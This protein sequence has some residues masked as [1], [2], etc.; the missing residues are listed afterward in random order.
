MERHQKPTQKTTAIL[1][2]GLLTSLVLLGTSSEPPLVSISDVPNLESGTRVELIGLLVELRIYDSGAEGLVLAD[3]DGGF[4]ARV[5]CSGG[6]RP[7]PSSYTSIGDE[8]RVIGDISS[9]ETGTLVFTDSDKIAISRESEA[10]LSVRTV[11]S[12]WMLFE[13]DTIRINGIVEMDGSGSGLRLVECSGGCSIAVGTNQVSLDILVGQQVI[14]TATLDF[15]RRTS[16][17]VL[18]VLYAVPEP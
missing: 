11:S 8:L 17:L 1:L 7:Q 4:T 14:V 13:G 10:V 16:S 15:D 3:A 6:I 18:A 5:V 9:G 12:N 2:V